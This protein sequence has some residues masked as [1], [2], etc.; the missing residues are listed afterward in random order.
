MTLKTTLLATHRLNSQNS[1]STKCSY[2][3]IVPG[4]AGQI[5]FNHQPLNAHIA[6][7]GSSDD[8]TDKQNIIWGYVL[9]WFSIYYYMNLALHH[10]RRRRRRW[11]R[12]A[13]LCQCAIVHHRHYY[14]CHRLVHQCYVSM[15]I[16]IKLHSI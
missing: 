1:H 3:H 9:T 10:I 4:A 6:I 15:T 2:D 14:T 12:S 13:W 16:I 11:C 8:D 5:M 7:N